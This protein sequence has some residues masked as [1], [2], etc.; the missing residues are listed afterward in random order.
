[1]QTCLYTVCNQSTQL[2]RLGRW[3]APYQHLY[4][5]S[6]SLHTVHYPTHLPNTHTHTP[7]PPVTTILPGI[8]SKMH[9][10][11]TSPGPQLRKQCF[12]SHPLNINLL[13]AVC[14]MIVLSHTTRTP[15]CADSLI[16]SLHGNCSPANARKPSKYY[17][18]PFFLFSL[19]FSRVISCCSK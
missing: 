4:K 19:F 3:Q 14:T 8:C 7:Y 6:S 13:T 11:R 15:Q 18:F 9:T 5:Q 16:S 17:E 1:M 2:N 10:L 12:S